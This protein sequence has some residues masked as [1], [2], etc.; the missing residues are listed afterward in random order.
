M[1]F[2]LVSSYS[3]SGDQPKAIVELVKNINN[4]IKSQVLL[5]VTGSGKTFT[6]ANA[7]AKTNRP[8]LVISH[9]KTLAAQ[10]Y[11]E[12]RSFFPNNAVEYFVS[13]YDYYQPEVYLPVSNLYIEKELAINEELEKLR[14]STV[15]SLLSGRQDIIV[16]ASVSCI[17][18]VG[19]PEEFKKNTRT[20]KLTEQLSR[21]ELLH[22]FVD[23]LYSRNDTEWTRGNFRVI[24]DTIDLFVAYGNYGYRFVF[25]GDEIE[26]IYQIDP[27]SGKQAETLTEVTIFPANLFVMHC[28]VLHE[29][30]KQ[31]Q[32]DLGK[33][34]HHFESIGK[35]EEAKRLKERTEL[36]IEMLKE[37]GYC[38]GIENYSRYVDGRAAGERPFCLLDYFPEDYLMVIDESHVTIPQFR[39]MWGGDHARKVNLV[40]YGFRLPSAIDNRPLHFDEFERLIN[41][42]IFVSATPADYELKASEGLIVEQII[43]PTGLL[44]PEI[45][46]KPTKNQIKDILTEIDQV[47]RKEERVFITTL[48]KRMAEEL[49][50]YLVE[51]NILCKYM[52][53]DIKT[54]D[55]V[56]ILNELREGV[57]DVLVGVNLLREGL[58]LPQ[59][60]LM[61]ILDADKEGFLR[62]TRSLIQ[63]IGRVARH[64]SGRVVMY[65]DRC[66]AS[67]EAAI[68]ETQRRRHL[69]MTYNTNHQIIPTAI[70]KTSNAMEFKQAK[71]HHTSTYDNHQEL[72][73][74]QES[75]VPY[76]SSLQEQIQIIEK[77]MY[78]AAAELRFVEA[79]KLKTLLEQLKKNQYSPG[80]K[81]V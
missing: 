52:H 77:K 11:S 40:E 76:G 58:D 2:E 78:Q 26:A 62:N 28:D 16:V 22:I 7:I 72:A 67:M 31:M 19:K 66:T 65:A 70:K 9:N 60:S 5:G 68:Q 24:G 36:D 50:T 25:W 3:P 20:F 39:A 44:D 10:L 41:Q 63:T 35:Y 37:L 32:L 75:V 47:V 71:N 8:T 49:T 1:A 45:E 4:G 81:E 43:R 73:M 33:Q 23:M 74:V 69:Q 59:V 13:Y 14:L 42:V 61:L 48:T 46:V 38:P 57:F 30:V 15:T 79:D 56:T 6:V 80:V 29:V 55:R 21:N 54:L 18:G 27:I 34:L 51:A 64:T 17:Y 12:L 53:S